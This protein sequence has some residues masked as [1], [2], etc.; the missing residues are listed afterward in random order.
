MIG[1]L[2]LILA[3]YIIIKFITGVV[4]PVSKAAKTMRGKVNEMRAEFENKA[5]SFTNQ[6]NTKQ[7]QA[8]QPN[9]TAKPAADDYLEFEE[10]K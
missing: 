3:A 10:I 7:T 4:M 9:K 1:W 8:A 6:Y 5:A 2:L